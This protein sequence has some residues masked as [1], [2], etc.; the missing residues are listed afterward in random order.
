MEDF[1]KSVVSKPVR[2][3]L[4]LAFVA[5]GSVLLNLMQFVDSF[6]P[7]GGRPYQYHEWTTSDFR[8][9]QLTDEVERLW[10]EKN[11]LT[12]INLALE[13]KLEAMSESARVAWS[14]QDE[15]IAHFRDEAPACPAT[16]SMRLPDDLFDDDGR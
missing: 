14:L 13:G 1:R 12:M 10:L 15:L 5:V 7:H 9:E 16:P 3:P 4:I 11:H 8:N 2:W 6:G